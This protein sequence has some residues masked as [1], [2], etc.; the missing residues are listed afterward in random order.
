MAK[1]SIQTGAS[2]IIF[3]V[4]IQHNRSVSGVGLTGLSYTS[5]NLVCYYIRNRD[6]AP[7]SIPLVTVPNQG[8]YTSGGFMER[9]PIKCP[10]LYQFHPPNA[11]FAAG[12]E[13][14][15]FF[16][17]GHLLMVP[18]RIDVELTATN[19]QD[20]IR[21]GM[22]ALPNFTAASTGGLPTVDASN[23]VKVQAPMK[24][25]T[26]TGFPF[27]M[28]DSSKVPMTGLH[29][30]TSISKDDA[31]FATT[32]NNATE[33]G[34]GWYWISFTALETN[35]ATLVFHATASGAANTDSV[36]LFVP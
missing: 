8:A 22:T 24:K 34:N 4:F 26:V 20:A 31:A 12:A 25:G 3:D 35:A 14:V 15:K 7:V 23:S 30:A 5:Q 36:L 28:F 10:G 11:A 1:R 18:T 32:T 27:Q 13:E 9:D 6:T 16:L 17:Q 29:P 21:G 2:S 19:N 33:L